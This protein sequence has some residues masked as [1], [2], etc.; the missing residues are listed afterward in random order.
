MENTEVYTSDKQLK[1][2]YNSLEKGSLVKLLIEKQRQLEKEVKKLALLRVVESAE[3]MPELKQCM[4]GRDAECSH[5]KCPISEEDMNNGI[6]CKLPL[7][8]YRE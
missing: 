5:P 2:L 6:Y 4:M 1:E 7:H 8:D 3:N